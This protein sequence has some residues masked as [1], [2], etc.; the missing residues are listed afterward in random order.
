[1]FF[2][3]WLTCKWHVL[4]SSHNRSYIDGYHSRL[5][6]EARVHT[7]ETAHWNVQIHRPYLQIQLHRFNTDWIKP[8]LPKTVGRGFILSLIVYSPT[9][10]K[11]NIADGISPSLVTKRVSFQTTHGKHTS[12]RGGMVIFT[13][14]VAKST[15]VIIRSNSVPTFI[16]ITGNATWQLFSKVK[17]P[18]C[19]YDMSIDGSDSGIFL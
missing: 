4:Y 12:C 5:S 13:P 2:L 3:Y 17:L 10:G 19:N 8:L 14:D 18:I 11:P 1:M 6:T 16:V 9:A 15:E 7:S